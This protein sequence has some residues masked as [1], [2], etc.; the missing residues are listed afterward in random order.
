MHIA[1]EPYKF[2]VDNYLVGRHELDGKYGNISVVKS[3][4]FS[5]VT[6]KIVS[7]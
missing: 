4:F 6:A 5:I 3:V 7:K 2:K 1:T